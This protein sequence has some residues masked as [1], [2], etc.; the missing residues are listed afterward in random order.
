MFHNV[1]SLIRSMWRRQTLDALK[2][3]VSLPCKSPAFDA[4]W[5]EHRYLHQ[6]AHDAA[7]WGSQLFPNA[8][9]EVVETQGRTPCLFFDIPATNTN[10]DVS[11]LFYG[12]LDKQ[13]ETVGWEEGRSAFSPCVE[14]NRLYGRGCADDGYSVYAALTAIHALDSASIARPRAVG[15]IETCEE[16]GHDD[17]SYCLTSLASRCGHVSL[18]CGLDG[19]AGDYDRLWATTSFR[20]MVAATL[21]VEILENGVHSGTASGIVPDSFSLVRQLLDRFENSRTGEILDRAFHTIAPEARIEQLRHTAEVLKDNYKSNFPWVDG[22]HSR[23]ENTFDNLLAQTWKPQ[24]AVI[25]AQ[26]LPS[27]QDAG[28]VLRPYTALKLSVR[29]PAHVDAQAALTSMEHTL[30][31]A[32]PCGSRVKLFDCV[33]SDGWDAKPEQRWFALALEEASIELFGKSAA[34]IADGASIPILNHFED[35]FPSA[36]FLITGVLGPNSNA[37]GPNE[38]LRLDYVEKLTQAIARIVS[39]VPLEKC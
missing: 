36:Q 39:R 24:L 17:L 32:P 30:T 33:A 27:L 5:E 9:F 35:V 25:G 37:H 11:V 10:S 20:G 13:P 19:S 38:M 29:V 1:D 34:Y 8:T 23:H 28:N 7:H 22:A 21:C 14:E 4:Q 18:R 6:A 2:T 15:I 3:F 31:Q 12:H 16:T 26:G